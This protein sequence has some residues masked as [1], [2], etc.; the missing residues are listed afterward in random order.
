MNKHSV[1]RGIFSNQ[2][3]KK[4][5]GSC[6]QKEDNAKYEILRMTNLAKPMVHIQGIGLAVSKLDLLCIISPFLFITAVD[7]LMNEVKFRRT[8][9]CSWY[10]TKQNFLAYADDRELLQTTHTGIQNMPE[11]V[12]MIVESMGL[13]VNANETKMLKSGYHTTN[14]IQS[15]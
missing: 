1:D 14:K 13:N 15:N 5:K 9:G 8:L 6:P 2:L 12:Y 7:Y 3:V 11:K 4:S 10:Q